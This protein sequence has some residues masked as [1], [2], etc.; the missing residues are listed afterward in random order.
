MTDKRAIAAATIATLI[1]GAGVHASYAQVGPTTA[2]PPPDGLKEGTGAPFPKGRYAALDA[3]PD[4]GGIW[5]VTFNRPGA[6]GP[7]P[8][9]PPGPALKGKYKEQYE[10]WRARIKANN[11]VDKS[12]TS[13]CTAPG[14][15][16]IM[17][18]PQYPYEFLFTPGRVTINQEAW[19]QTRH[20]WTDGRAHP[21]DPEPGFFGHSVGHWEGGVLVADTIGIKDTVPLGMGTS[22][23]DKMRV[24]ERIHLKDG[25]PDTLLDEIT[26]DDPE[27]LEQPYH[28]T[29]VYHRDRYGQLL[30]FE[31]AENDRNPVDAQGDTGFNR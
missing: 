22:H 14:L 21:D 18:L 30:E 17:S 19:M 7:P 11:G 16:Q 23:S 9:P 13:H 28:T 31:C 15:P 27:A 2:S 20:I 24:S 5:F 12:V 8:A 1:L 10:A 4:W 25:D 26:V 29:A 6:G 3:L